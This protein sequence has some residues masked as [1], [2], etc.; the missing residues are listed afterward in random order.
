MCILSEEKKI[1]KKKKNL[2][3]LSDGLDQRNKLTPEARFKLHAVIFFLIHFHSRC[4]PAAILKL[5]LKVTL[6]AG[7]IT[8]SCSSG[9]PRIAPQKSPSRRLDKLQY[10]SPEEG[11]EGTK[12]GSAVKGLC[13]PLQKHSSLGSPK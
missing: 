9:A 5:R 12:R 1:K 3:G 8:G 10:P 11:A 6:M 7:V 13:F 4:S 2:V